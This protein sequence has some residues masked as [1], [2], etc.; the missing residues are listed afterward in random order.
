MIWVNLKAALILTEIHTTRQNV[1]L[2]IVATLYYHHCVP[3]VV[4]EILLSLRA[5]L[6]SQ[7]ASSSENAQAWAFVSRGGPDRQPT[8]AG[9]SQVGLGRGL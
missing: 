3:S 2:H 8:G 6:T 4:C 7:R 5:C 1:T 9:V